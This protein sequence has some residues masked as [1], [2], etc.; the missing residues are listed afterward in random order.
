MISRHAI[1]L[2][3]TLLAAIFAIYADIISRYCF[4]AAT[5][6]LLIMLSLLMPPLPIAA[7]D[8]TACFTAY[9]ISRAACRVL[10]ATSFVAF[11]AI[12]VIIAAFYAGI[13]ALITPI[14][15]PLMPPWRL[16]CRCCCALPL[17]LPDTLAVFIFIV[18]IFSL[19]C[20]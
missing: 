17:F 7:D 16:R 14:Y 9:A 2:L 15:A 12:D 8:V 10:E 6:M 11:H 4:D 5:P 19:R 20:R 3:I 1:F 18:M 13:A